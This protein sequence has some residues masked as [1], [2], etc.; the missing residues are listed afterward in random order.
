MSVFG[1]VTIPDLLAANILRS[2]ECGTI[3]PFKQPLTPVG[4]I[5][6]VNSDGSSFWGAVSGVSTPISRTV[7]VD[8]FENLIPI[9]SPSVTDMTVATRAVPPSIGLSVSSVSVG[10]VVVV[11]DGVGL[12]VV[13]VVVV[14]GVDIDVDAA[15][16][17]GDDMDVVVVGVAVS[18]DPEQ[19][20]NGM[21][22]TSNTT[23]IVCF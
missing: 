14:D 18:S 13:V 1:S 3:R 23:A 15:V 22:T 9:V 2:D 8:P 20:A 4:G 6:D 7:S 21:I 17:L 5:R 16:T 19:P 11:V 10:V 12:A